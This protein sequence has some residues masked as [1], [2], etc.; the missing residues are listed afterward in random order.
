MVAPINIDEKMST[1][2]KM[3]VL[4]F[5]PLVGMFDS[6]V[7]FVQEYWSNYLSSD[8]GQWQITDDNFVVPYWQYICDT[9]HIVNEVVVTHHDCF[10]VSNSTRLK[11]SISYISK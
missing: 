11:T 9:F 8:V 4:E 5:F 6:R 10:W 3:Q 1:A 2:W 7:L